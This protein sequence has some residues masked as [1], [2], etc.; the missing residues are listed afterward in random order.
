MKKIYN[1]LTGI[2]VSVLFACSALYAGTSDSDTV[3]LKFRNNVSIVIIADENDDLGSVTVYDLNKILENLNEKIETETSDVEKAILLYNA[4]RDDIYYDPYN[5]KLEPERMSA[6]YTLS[7]KRNYCIPKATL[8]A[9][10]ARAVG[11]PSRLGFAD[12]KN[13][14]TT[15]KF[16]TLMRTDVFAYHGY[17]ELYLNDRWVKATPTFNRSLCEKFHIKPLEFDGRNDSI[18]HEYDE[19]G[20]KHMEYIRD[21][22]QYADV[23][24]D[25]I[26]Q[27]FKKH[28]P[29]LIPKKSYSINGNFED[30]AKPL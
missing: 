23:P 18:F 7:V 2:A 28:Y 16:R 15:E 3:I 21:H 1:L 10:V 27:S 14:L 12:V 24:L 29:H 17:T 13:H 26:I 11:I 5:V 25:D 6:S 20:N 19:K 30:E 8:L 4:V 9:A 22:G